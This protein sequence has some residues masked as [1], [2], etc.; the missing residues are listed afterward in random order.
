M[1]S[2]FWQRP[3]TAARAPG[4]LYKSGRALD[5]RNVVL[6]EG[7]ILTTDVPGKMGLSQRRGL[8]IIFPAR[9]L[10]LRRR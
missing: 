9:G 8:M 4:A 5:T 6:A 3:G 2:Y 7:D 10:G 1:T